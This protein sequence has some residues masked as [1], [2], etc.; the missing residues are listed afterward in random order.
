MDL[1]ELGGIITW[2][3]PA[4]VAYSLD[5]ACHISVL[6]FGADSKVYTQRYL[7]YLAEDAVGTARSQAEERATVPTGPKRFLSM[8]A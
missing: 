7:V 3:P 6:C 5:S 1:N 8:F 2:S 4:W